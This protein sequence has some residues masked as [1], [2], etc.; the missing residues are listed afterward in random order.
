MAFASSASFRYC[1]CWALRR[2]AWARWCR[3]RAMPAAIFIF[4]IDDTLCWCHIYYFAPYFFDTA[5]LLTDIIIIVSGIFFATLHAA[6]IIACRAPARL[7]PPPPLFIT[8]FDILRHIAAAYFHTFT[9]ALMP[10][11]YCHKG[12]YYFID[13][14]ARH[15]VTPRHVDISIITYHESVDYLFSP[16]IY[17]ITMLMPLAIFAAMP[18]LPLLDA[19]FHY[20][21]FAITLRLLICHYFSLFHFASELHAATY[22]LIFAIRHW[23]ADLYRLLSMP[24]AVVAACASCFFADY[25]AFFFA[26]LP[27]RHTMLFFL[28]ELMFFVMRAPLSPCRRRRRDKAATPYHFRHKI[29]CRWYF[30]C[31][32]GA[33]TPTL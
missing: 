11:W 25:A 1:F 27:R 5:L 31:C 19:A 15:A 21:A 14:F 24:Y 7:M 6:I 30:H 20:S 23:Y 28:F 12:W 29:Y 8:M 22:M 33:D 9:L 13:I 10:C 18:L 16:D 32:S 4:S 3:W 2:H 26:A 17:A